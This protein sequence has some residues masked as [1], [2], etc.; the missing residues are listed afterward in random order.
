MYWFSNNQLKHGYQTKRA[1]VATYVL[2]FGYIVLSVVAWC[3]LTGDDPN[4][5]CQLDAPSLIELMVD[6]IILLYMRSLRLMSILVFLCIC[7]IPILYC[8]LKNRPRPT[9]NP[10]KLKANLNI[11]TLGS[12]YQLRNMNYRHKA[13]ASKGKKVKPDELSQ[14]LIDKTPTPSLSAEAPSEDFSMYGMDMTCCICME[15]F[16]E[17]QDN[18]AGNPYS[19]VEVVILPCKAHYFHEPCIAAWMEKQNA[20]PVCRVEITID[21][22][23]RQKKEL[24]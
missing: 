17:E 3:M 19:S 21:G 12:L 7:G 13:A 16:G 18:E 9:Q 11:V 4:S 23:K 20:C 24:A 14:S 22:L 8:Y 5:E 2:E 10:E 15:N 1:V 6:M